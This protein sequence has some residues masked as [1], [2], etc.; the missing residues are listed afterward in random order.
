M[1]VKITR[2]ECCIELDK[3]QWSRLEKL[4]FLDVVNPAL[5]KVGVLNGTVEY[6]GHFGSN[7]FYTVDADADQ[8][9]IVQ[10]LTDLIGAGSDEAPAPVPAEPFSRAARDILA[11][12]VRQISQE[13]CTN[14][15]DDKY[16]GCELAA[17]AATYALC[18]KPSQLSVCGVNA[19]PWSAQAW[20]PSHYRGN[21]VKAGAL[22]LAELER[23]DRRDGNV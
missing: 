3:D 23:I 7:I 13:G 19:W 1:Q 11:E 10:V 4:D 14:E 22:M 18:T 12:R 2:H 16:T 6:D 5:V 8:S 15:A 17:A 21:L 20:N 9:A